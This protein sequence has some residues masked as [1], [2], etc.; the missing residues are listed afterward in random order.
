[1]SGSSLLSKLPRS[2][3][4][5]IASSVEEITRKAGASSREDKLLALASHFIGQRI[6][7]GEAVLAQRLARLPS[8]IKEQRYCGEEALRNLL[9][10]EHLDI[11]A[12]LLTTNDFRGVGQSH[13]TVF[14]PDSRQI[15]DW[16]EV[17]NV[18]RNG[19]DLLSEKGRLLARNFTILPPLFLFSEI[20]KFK[21]ENLLSAFSGS[22][23][24]ID[25]VEYPSGNIESSV[26][27]HEGKKRLSIS[28]LVN[29]L[30]MNLPFFHQTEMSVQGRKSLTSRTVGLA[31]SRK[32]N[33]CSKIAI[34]YEVNGISSRGNFGE[35]L[36]PEE[37]EAFVLGMAYRIMSKNGRKVLVSDA[38]SGEFLD[39]LR[40]LAS[41]DP[42][43]LVV[44]QAQAHLDF[45]ETLNQAYGKK[46]AEI[47]LKATKFKIA[48]RDEHKDPLKAVFDYSGLNSLQ[49][50][51]N[52]FVYD[53]LGILN[54]YYFKGK[55]STPEK[56]LAGKIFERQ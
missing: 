46:K 44:R 54:R 24:L 56:L 8:E 51:G 41:R 7:C 33:L 48:F 23:H 43:S 50:L 17:I 19:K 22:P 36:R 20:G 35:K 10:L 14:L 15:L 11:P 53:S 9:F 37:K 52:R 29:D 45:Y 18:R 38:E 49:D 25:R 5:F 30:A 34:T 40:A 26:S 3:R 16:G 31:P 32:G 27:Y 2:E 39:Y 42:D 21:E 6:G 47:Y 28:H 1:M 12:L 4:E 55:Q 13:D